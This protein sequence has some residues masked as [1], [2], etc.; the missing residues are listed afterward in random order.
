MMAKTD[1]EKLDSLVKCVSD[2]TGR[3][4]PG[5]ADLKRLIRAL[6]YDRQA[7]EWF[8]DLVHAEEDYVLGEAQTKER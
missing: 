2:W 3:N 5:R 8:L 4:A 6:A 7:L 1:E